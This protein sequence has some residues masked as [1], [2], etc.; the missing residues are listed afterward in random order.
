M[1]H[2]TGYLAKPYL[3]E[4]FLRTQDTAPWSAPELT[5][6]SVPGLPGRPLGRPPPARPARET[7]ARGKRS[8]E[9][10]R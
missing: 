10:T 5:V 3:G 2:L 8:K 1:A 6:G 7:R 4:S 9:K